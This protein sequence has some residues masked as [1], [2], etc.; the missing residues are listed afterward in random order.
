VIR[1]CPEARPLPSNLG[2]VTA[3]AG[4][5]VGHVQDTTVGYGYRPTRAMAWLLALLLAGTVIYGLH[6]PRPVE[7]GKAPDFNVLIYTLDLLLPIIDFGQEKAFNPHSAYQWL[8]YLL[9]AAGWILATTVAP[10]SPAPSTGSDL[11]QELP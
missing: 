11:H 2:D 8:A 7:P 3:E 9:I 5:D 4:S 1:T 6:H 10:A